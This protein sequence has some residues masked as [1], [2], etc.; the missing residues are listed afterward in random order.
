M[1]H[2]TIIGGELTEVFIL[3]R[4]EVEQF[5]IARRRYDELRVMAFEVL[6]PAIGGPANPLSGQLYD[7]LQELHCRTRG[8]LA[9]HRA[10][11]EQRT[12]LVG[13]AQ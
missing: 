4:E 8:F 10:A 2:A 6:V 12:Q 9:S 1:S 13:G 3:T 7:L 11:S 5:A